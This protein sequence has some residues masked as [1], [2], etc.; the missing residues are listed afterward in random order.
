M[1]VCLQG[2]TERYDENGV[3]VD[4]LWVTGYHRTHPSPVPLYQP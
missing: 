1:T 3:A 2:L 4:P